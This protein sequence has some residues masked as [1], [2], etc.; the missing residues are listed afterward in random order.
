MFEAQLT[1]KSILKPHRFLLVNAI[2]SLDQ[3]EPKAK[4]AWENL[5]LS[6]KI[7]DTMYSY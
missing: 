5:S 3:F 4:S 1:Q 2:I 6:R 7:P